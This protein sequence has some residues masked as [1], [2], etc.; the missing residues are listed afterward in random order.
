[1][2]LKTKRLYLR[3]WR[4]GDKEGLLAIANNR[5]IWRNMTDAFSY[6][7]TPEEADNW[8]LKNEDTEKKKHTFAIIY[9]DTIIGGIGFD[10]QKDTHRKTAV[11]GY[12]LGEPYWGKGFAPEA[13]E[14]VTAYAFNNF[15]IERMEARVFSWNPKSARVLEKAGYK[16]E[17][18]LHNKTFKD[19]ELIDELVYYML[20][21][22]FEEKQFK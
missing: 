18:T 16:F 1:M 5:K 12:W 7:Y 19:G 17:A 2:E 11:I 20:R 21:K 6:P 22:D 14:T 3:D 15:D 10:F 13:L 4:K 8:I 9:Q